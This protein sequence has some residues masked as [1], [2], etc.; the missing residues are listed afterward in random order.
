MSYSSNEVTS[1]PPFSFKHQQKGDESRIC[2]F[3]ANS[4]G[5]RK[6][7]GKLLTPLHSKKEEPR[8]RPMEEK[9][10]D[11]AHRVVITTAINI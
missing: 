5:S 7:A 4:G 6:K 9:V 8:G 3:T 10:S 2:Y 1:Q 11:A